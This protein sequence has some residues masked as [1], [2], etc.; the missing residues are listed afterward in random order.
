MAQGPDDITTRLDGIQARLEESGDRLL[1]FVEKRVGL[2]VDQTYMQR[3]TIGRRSPN[4]SGPL[5][6][7]ASRLVRSLTG[8]TYQGRQEGVRSAT[9]EGTDIIIRYGS[10]VPYAAVHEEGFQG[11]VQIPAHSR[12]QTQAFG[13]KIDPPQTVQVSAHSREMSIPARP[14]LSP[15]LRDEMPSIRRK[16]ADE[17]QGAILSAAD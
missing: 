1:E 13:R 16:A 2:R 15:A 3:D 4:D 7:Q 9:T 14:Y 5:R 11:T 17:L 10:K 12:T 6:I 8:R